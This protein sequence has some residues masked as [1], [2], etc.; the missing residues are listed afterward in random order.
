M[1]TNSPY[2]LN[3]SH[4]VGDANFTP[5]FNEHSGAINDLDSRVTSIKNGGA[6]AYATASTP[7][8]PGA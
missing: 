1:A 4:N 3:A 7:E 8:T 2:N 6:T 5:A